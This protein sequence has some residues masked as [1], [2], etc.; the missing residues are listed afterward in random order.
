MSLVASLA[1]PARKFVS[2]TE[3]TIAYASGNGVCILTLS[4]N[5]M[6]FMTPGSS[7]TSNE[8]KRDYLGGI[9]A[10]GSSGTTSQL[11]IAARSLQPCIDVYDYPSMNKAYTLEGGAELDFADI[12]F[13]ANGGRVAAISKLPDFS[14]C[15]WDTRTQKII[16][17]AT[18]AEPCTA[19]SFNPLKDDQLCVHGEKGLFLWTMKETQQEGI[20]LESIKLRMRALLD[21]EEE[22][23][24]GEQEE[25][26]EDFEEAQGP[27]NDFV[28]HCWSVNGNI[29]AATRAGEAFTLTCTGAQIIETFPAFYTSSGA[30]D[31]GPPN[32][33]EPRLVARAMY[34]TKAHIVVVFSD[35]KVRW[36]QP[37]GTYDI[38]RVVNLSSFSD[39]DASVAMGMDDLGLDDGLDG[40]KS[41]EGGGSAWVVP[42]TS[43]LTPGHLTISIGTA[44]GM[45]LSLPTG[46]DE[47]TDPDD[48][49]IEVFA[50][51]GSEVIVNKHID[52]HAD[53]VYAMCPVKNQECVL[54]AA[55]DG[56]VRLWD[57]KHG[58]LLH[59]TILN[60][61]PFVCASSS[62]SSSLVA[63]G[64]VDGVVRLLLVTRQKK[65]S[66]VIIVYE[67]KLFDKAVT[68][69]DFHPA[70]PIL[71]VTSMAEGRIYLLD[72]RPTS[73]GPF[74]TCSTDRPYA[75]AWCGSEKMLVASGDGILR[76]ATLPSLP[77]KA[78]DID[79]MR[80]SPFTLET[81][82]KFARGSVL[83]MVVDQDGKTLYVANDASK[84]LERFVLA[85][86][87]GGVDAKLVPA[88]QHAL[89][90]QPVLSVVMHQRSNGVSMLATGGKSGM[91]GVW[92]TEN[93]EAM[94]VKEIRGHSAGVV[95]MCF[96]GNGERLMTSSVDGS[97]SMWEVGLDAGAPPPA[98]AT[99]GSYPSDEFYAEN[100]KNLLVENFD[101]MSDDIG[102]RV[103]FMERIEAADREVVGLQNEEKKA[104]TLSKFHAFRLELQGLMNH[105]MTVDELERLETDE[106][107]VNLEEKDRLE[108]EGGERSKI[109]EQRIQQENATRRVI[110]KRLMSEL[111][112]SMEYKGREICSVKAGLNL[113][114][115]N[116]PVPVVTTERQ[117]TYDRALMHRRIELR[118]IMQAHRMTVWPGVSEETNSGSPLTWMVNE[119]KLAPDPDVKTPE[120]IL[121]LEAEAAAN[122]D[123]NKDNEDRGRGDDGDGDGSD[124]VTK[125][126]ELLDMLYRPLALRTNAQKR[127][128]ILLL[129]QLIREMKISFNKKFDDCFGT[130]EEKLDEIRNK[131]IRIQEILN[132]LK[133]QEEYFKPQWNSSEFPE[134]VVEVKD[135]EVPVE[136]YISEAERKKMADDEEERKRNA[137]ANQGDNAPERALMEM[138][139]GT[140]EEEQGLNA[141]EQELVREEWMDELLFDEMSED[142]IKMLEDFEARQKALLEEK[143]K[144]RKGLELELKKLDRM[145]QIFVGLL[146]RKSQIF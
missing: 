76:Q 46:I 55:A 51:G 67:E 56:S 121:A 133:V 41:G 7:T 10:L 17:R 82:G 144:Y 29:H 78:V 39:T 123:S 114:V 74:T 79:T 28:C 97:V 33:D 2:I 84:S 129:E 127:I 69:L 143:E 137:A 88:G 145:C 119:G 49:E 87:C 94:L 132:E 103:S 93:G 60:S 16:C 18:L 105:N 71:S 12:T 85:E 36:L 99:S 136:K 95:R 38:H 115:T 42:I 52:V 54:T 139:G 20:Q 31:A 92:R 83:S 135:T 45:I 80:T 43:C 8:D 58:A 32:D 63:L 106:F 5:A 112:N 24:G 90:V 61:Q 131:N 122:E 91:I 1:F 37:S 23:S 13:S 138:M 141:L 142:Q 101:E 120:Q 102:S 22:D 62:S 70:Q 81:R 100:T 108:R 9:S 111:W 34:M 27:R 107:I 96:V 134:R 98:A 6:K 117:T 146:M 65:S 75:T 86:E 113:K 124:A 89:H 73:F 35:G 59:K 57:A 104:E 109:V 3:D 72:V 53:S 44:D 130:K 68:Q 19:I 14:I 125:E 50:E 140:L 110:W 118:E 40:N 21:D 25:D 66:S 77:E 128:Q 15:V 64:S 116:F 48:F 30:T 11:A 126:E 26:D 4:T 47:I